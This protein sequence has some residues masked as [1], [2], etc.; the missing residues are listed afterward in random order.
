MLSKLTS[1]QIFWLPITIAFYLA[2]RG[3]YERSGRTP[4]LNT[5]L[6]TVLAVVVALWLTGTS[7]QQYLDDV[8]IVQFL[9]GTAVVALAVPLHRN[10]TH[11]SGNLKVFLGTLLVTCATSTV[12]GLCIA[13][14][15]GASASTLLSIAPKSATTAV[16]IEIANSVGGI[17]ALTAFVTVLTG[18]I[19]AVLGPYVLSSCAIKTPIARGLALGAASHGIGTARALSEGEITGCWA[20]LAMGGNAI[21]TALTVPWILSALGIPAP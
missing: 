16:S 3:L 18:I 11:L 7:P 6:F 21:L 13:R 1:G 9:L 10:L 17:P 20:S 12:I 8:A 19:G 4:F 15:L 14:S 2:F 5:T